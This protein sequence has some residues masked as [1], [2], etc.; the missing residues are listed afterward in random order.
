MQTVRAARFSLLILLSV[1]LFS[2]LASAQHPSVIEPYEV[3][4]GKP[5]LGRAALTPDQMAPSAATLALV[6][7]RTETMLMRLGS[8]LGSLSPGAGPPKLQRW[9]ATVQKNRTEAEKLRDRG[10]HYAA[11]WKASKDFILAEFLTGVREAVAKE[12]AQDAGLGAPSSRLPEVRAR[13]DA[14]YTQLGVVRV[15]S[16]SVA[17][18]LSEAYST[19]VDLTSLLDLLQNRPAQ[20][21]AM[22]EPAGITVPP[23]KQERFVRLLMEPIFIPIISWAMEESDLALRASQADLNGVIVPDEAALQ[24]LARA[25]A[26]AAR[27]NLLLARSQREGRRLPDRGPAREFSGRLT[28]DQIEQGLTYE[29]QH[30]TDTGMASA[31]L[32]LGTSRSAYAFSLGELAETQVQL[33]PG[34]AAATDSATAEREMDRLRTHRL[35]EYEPRA[36]L[37]AAQAKAIVG[38]VPAFVGLAYLRGQELHDDEDLKDRELAVGE[39][40]ESFT[41]AEL[42]AALSAPPPGGAMPI[43]DS[44]AG[45]PQEFI[46]VCIG[47]LKFA[48]EGPAFK[49]LQNQG[50]SLPQQEFR[51]L[52]MNAVI[53]TCTSAKDLTSSMPRALFLK[54]FMNEVMTW[55]REVKIHQRAM[56]KLSKVCS[57]LPRPDLEL[58]ERQPCTLTQQAMSMLDEDERQIIQWHEVE[59]LTFE[60]IAERLGV[61]NKATVEKRGQRALAKLRAAYKKLDPLSLSW[62]LAPGGRLR[63][64]LWLAIRRQTTS[65]SPCQSS[66]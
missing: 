26:D 25:Y 48:M 7:A 1:L 23:E 65:G 49:M 10:K 38:Q 58:L 13:L 47:R 12:E 54:V 20:L 16:A 37:A 44:L 21:I 43:D 41:L 3:L 63:A 15:S 66:S 62:Q 57:T 40:I 45:A 31:L 61:K 39:L 9:S 22:L 64:L 42:A 5:Q 6:Q 32:L 53:Q 18:A 4:Y 17:L 51:E 55:F 33:D 27:A 50:I 11:W 14:F 19:W 24:K 29:R 35:Y 30:R 8:V 34:V 36:R 59:D 28:G 52:F 56:P 46:R 2:P 60:E